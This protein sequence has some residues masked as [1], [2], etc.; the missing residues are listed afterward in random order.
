MPEGQKEM[1]SKK[2]RAA[3]PEKNNARRAKR[4]VVKKARAAGPERTTPEGR[5]EMLSKKPGPQAQEKTTPGGCPPSQ[6]LSKR[7][8]T[9]WKKLRL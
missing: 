5:K 8:F 9:F 7:S 3:G 6:L 4:N 1:L 2:A